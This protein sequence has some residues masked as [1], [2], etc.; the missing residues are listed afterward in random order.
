M[1]TYPFKAPQYPPSSC[2]LQGSEKLRPK[3][4]DN[5][6]SHQ[7]HPANSTERGAKHVRFCLFIISKVCNNSVILHYLLCFVIY[8]YT[9]LFPF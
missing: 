4:G 6:A 3:L 9:K 2:I 1:S 7:V 8:I 5:R